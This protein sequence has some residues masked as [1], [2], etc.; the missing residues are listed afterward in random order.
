M[1]YW[2]SF[3]KPWSHESQQCSMNVIA[4]S[5]CSLITMSSCHP[6][7]RVFLM[8]WTLASTNWRC[9]NG[10]TG[11]H[12]YT[13]SCN[14][15][16][17]GEGQGRGLCY[18]FFPRNSYV[19]PVSLAIWNKRMYVSWMYVSWARFLCSVGSTNQPYNP[20]QTFFG[21]FLRCMARRLRCT[22]TAVN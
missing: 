17:W 21:S 5:L 13:F 15:L 14:T 9:V 22:H 12:N 10:N 4:L 6:G 7:G 2:S 20:M 19:N 8:V 16:L 1:F 3:L 18:A 11:P